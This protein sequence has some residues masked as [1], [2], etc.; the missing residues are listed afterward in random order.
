M[1]PIITIHLVVADFYQD[2]AKDLLTGAREEIAKYKNQPVQTVH[3]AEVKEI[4]VPGALEIPAAIRYAVEGN[5]IEN[6]KQQTAGN[7]L[8][9]LG[10][11]ALG[12][13]IR[14]E[15][16]HYDIVA[17]E[18]ARGL[19]ILALDH[20]AAIGNGILTVENMAQAKIRANPGQVSDSGKGAVGNKGGFAARACLELLELKRQNGLI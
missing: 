2:I 16:S 10:F 6:E 1:I 17:G 9:H 15:T 12:C 13:V 11:V 7:Q 18:S 4:K 19:Q 14:G 5:K 3:I 20:M 8:R